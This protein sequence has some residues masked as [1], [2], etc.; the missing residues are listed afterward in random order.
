MSTIKRMK[1]MVKKENW[2]RDNRNVLWKE[3]WVRH[4][5][6]RITQNIHIVKW[7]RK[8]A[9]KGSQVSKNNSIKELFIRFTASAF[10]KLPSI[11]VLSYFPFGSE[12]RVWD[13]IVSV[14]D[15]LSLL[16]F[17]LSINSGFPSP[18]QKSNPF[19]I[20]FSSQW[21]SSNQETQINMSSRDSNQS[22]P[23]LHT[24]PFMGAMVSPDMMPA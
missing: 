2:S 21:L 1:N 13:L 12:G 10:R 20:I 4:W 22:T 15:C 16:I 24:G 14:P 23:V 11:H 7:V 3:R 19:V 6:M 5:T 18:D 9:V 8:W 17:L